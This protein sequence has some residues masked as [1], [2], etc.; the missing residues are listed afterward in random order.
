MN[1]YKNRTVLVTG[2]SGFIGANLVRSLINQSAKVHLFLRPKAKIWRLTEIIKKTKIYNV[3][4]TDKQ[5]I[6]KAII[7]IKPQV[8]FHLAVYGAYPQQTNLGATI[9]TNI[10]G[11]VNLLEAIKNSQ[12]VLVNTGTSSEYGCKNKPMKE[13]DSLEP[14]FF[15]AASKAAT[16][17]LCRIF[18]QQFNQPIITLRPFSIYG[19][20]EEPERFVPTIINSCLKKQPIKL[21]AGK[22]VR[23]WLYVEDITRAY[24]MAGERSDLRG[25]IFNIGSGKQVLVSKVARKIIK[26]INNPVPV[27]IGAYKPRQWE[28]NNWQADIS[29]AKKILSWEPKYNLEQGLKKT[30]AWWGNAGKAR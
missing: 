21:V 1:S 11:T 13:T 14:A 23:D 19:D 12:T 28:A 10:I 24:L 29:K 2:G 26:L 18:S 22:Q 15:Y 6:E 7:K 17:Y 9:K 30:I 5:S 3:D 8:I 27:K 4:I 25:E 16:S 20:W